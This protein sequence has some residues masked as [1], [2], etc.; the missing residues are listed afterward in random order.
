[1]AEK[2][3]KKKRKRRSARSPVYAQAPPIGASLSSPERM[4]ELEEGRSQEAASIELG[5][6]G[7]RRSRGQIHEERLPELQGIKEFRTYDEMSK[8]DPVVGGMLFAIQMLIRQV[9]WSVT[10]AS[11]QPNDMEAADFLTSNMDDMSMTWED[12]IAEILSMIPFGFSVHELVY[13][14]RNGPDQEDS[15][16]RSKFSDGRIGWKK[17]PIRSQETVLEWIFD[18]T[19]GIRGFEQLDT[20]TGHRAIIPIEKMLLFRTTA[21]KGNPQ[22]R[23]V[24]RNAFRP[25]WFKKNIENIRAIGVERDLA[26]LP[27]AWVPTRLLDP[28]CTAADKATLATI[29]EIVT[30]VRRDEQEGLVLPLSYDENNNKMFDFGLLTT[31]GRRQHDTTKI[32]AEYNQMIATTI[33]ADFILLGHEKVGS[34]ALA[35]SKTDVFGLAIASWLD[36]IG[37]VFNRFAIPRLFALNDFNVTELP[38]LEHAPVETVDIDKLGD[39]LQKLSL[40]GAPIFPDPNLERWVKEQAG[41]PTTESQEV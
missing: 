29:K 16:Q 30:N 8:N 18:E 15:N 5:T 20:W 27:I 9:A 32:V 24:L 41:I 4:S 12:T 35:D 28:N 1:M 26:G 37:E 39:F 10:S 23:S 31:G 40:S 19:G 7:L 13:K 34:F 22:G 36:S 17:L 14:T 11:N 21:H 33:L 6:T 38:R 3:K 25:W 2:K